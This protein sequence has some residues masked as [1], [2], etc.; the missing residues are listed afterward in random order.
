MGGIIYQDP[1][2]GN[3]HVDYPKNLKKKKRGH[4]KALDKKSKRTENA[5]GSYNSRK[6][7]QTGLGTTKGVLL[8]KTS[9]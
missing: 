6:L 3:P 1:V 7:S 2:I 5:K 9:T 8:S 4:L